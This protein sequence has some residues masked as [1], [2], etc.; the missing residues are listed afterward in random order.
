M[1]AS[2]RSRPVSDTAPQLR[3]A[4]LVGAAVG[5]LGGIACSAA[6]VLA[7][8]GVI[9]AAATGGSSM[10]SMGQVSDGAGV[11]GFLLD[12]GPEILVVSVVFVTL[13]LA[14][15]R[16]LAAVGAALV[17]A[18][19][20]WGM[21]VQANLTTMYVTIALGLIAWLGLLLAA[22]RSATPSRG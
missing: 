1:K 17:G 7:A 12:H 2:P 8:V 20:Y 6:M 3:V 5:L 19:M 22:T 21:Y 11:S 14:L 15:R 16:S 18:I 10:S 9:G 13:A 4:S